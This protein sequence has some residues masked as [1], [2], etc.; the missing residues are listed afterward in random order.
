MGTLVAKFELFQLMS[1]GFPCWKVPLK[2]CVMFMV[3]VGVVVTVAVPDGHV[4]H[5]LSNP[6]IYALHE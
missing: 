2:G 5:V 4:E 3:G 6:V 1:I